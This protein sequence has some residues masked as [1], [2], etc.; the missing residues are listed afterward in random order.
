MCTRAHA[1]KR[2]RTHAH[3]HT[4]T[5]SHA[6]ERTRARMLYRATGAA[7]DQCYVMLQ[8][9]Q[10]DHNHSRP[11]H[12]PALVCTAVA[13]LSTS[14]VA[15]LFRGLATAQWSEPQRLR[16]PDLVDDRMFLYLQQIYTY[17]LYIYI[18]YIYI[19]KYDIYIYI[20]KY[21]I[22]VY[23]YMIYI[24]IYIFIDSLI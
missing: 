3:A 5:P 17:I 16:F 13:P 2:T 14:G 20:F 9:Q 19:Y 15:S 4:R 23:K 10:A 21:D 7:T 11:Q 1:Q 6:H 8:L 24:Y 18:I 12:T 22:Y